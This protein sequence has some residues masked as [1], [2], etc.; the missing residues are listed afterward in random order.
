MKIKK[1]LTTMAILTV[2]LFAGCKKDD[3]VE[4]IGV[5]PLVIST[6]PAN[7]A[8]S[9]PYYKVI[10][11]KFNEKMDAAT[12]TASSFTLQQ[13]T[14]A[15][16]GTVTYSDST[17][18]FTPTVAL[19]V[20][21]TYKGTIKNTAKDL[22]GNALQADYVWT[23]TTMPQ[24]SLQASPVI[25][26]TT[27][28]GGSFAIGASVTVTAT[29]NPG[30][31]FVN[32]TE[33]GTVVSLVNSPLQI[34]ATSL[35]NNGTEVSTSSS[36]TFIM[37]GNRTLTANFA[38]IVLGN[39]A[40]N[41]SSNPAAGG[42]TGGGGTFVENSSKTVTANANTGYTF[43]NWT[44]GGL[45]VSTNASYNFTLIANK[46]LVANFL[47]NT[48]SLTTS[49][50]NGSVAKS[51]SQA[52][53]NF[54]STVVLTPTANAGYSF[55]SWTGDA[56]GSSNPL[57][58]IMN[59]N[60]AITANFTLN[61][62]TL[63]VISNNGSV[64]KVPSQ[65]TYNHGSTVQ[66][67]ATA[68]FGYTFTSWSGDATG[69]TNPLNV[70][71]SS[72]KNITAN[73]TAIVGALTLNVTAVNGTV[74]KDP[75]L[76]GYLT[77][78]SVILTATPNAGYEF[79]SW[80]GDA[81]GSVNP[82]TIIMNANKNVTAN[83]TLSA[84]KGPGTINLGG[85]AI[86]S[87]LSKTGISTTVGT[88]VTG[89]IGVSPA[90]AT[91]ITGFGLIMDAT[92]TFSKSSP[93]TLVSGKVYAADYAA[94]TPANIST[95]ISDMETAFTTANGL[96]TTVITEL[97]AGDIT[98]MTLV[99]GLYKW[100]TGL[101][102]SASGVTLTGGAND[103]WVFQI[104]Q[105]MTV[106][107]GAIIHLAGGAQAKNIYWITASDAIINSTVEFNGNILSQTLIAL[108][109][110]SKVTGRLLGQTAVTLDAATV[111]FP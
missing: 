78:A 84:P 9:V 26:G 72:N 86:Y 102:I 55:T 13:G 4:T 54:G 104:G 43:V 1:L 11:A 10:T 75:N 19:A 12:I 57:S 71:M 23:F 56:S 96:T 107:S 27:I 59:A 92:N 69:S 91:A 109:T 51:P 3:Y 5:C 87:V 101:L 105:G 8:N 94:P 98:G 110:G 65:V 58:V 66:L 100:S 2:V 24:I 95:A 77:G 106:A 70:T 7:G 16:S 103:T 34:N 60:K 14:T 17:A 41:L 90:A 85:A 46:T 64:V 29:P 22:L 63:N 47:I 81:T 67:T 99:P 111:V 40:I 20:F 53:Y 83:F 61:T 38:V 30:Y 37:A 44:E 21:T 97:G 49:A 89:N 108:K 88:S 48:Y 39:F 76:I 45:I 18:T 79:T 35:A 28:G 31:V 42:T 36:Y 32:W 15:I 80:S 73:Y 25:G 52:T 33:N 93:S 68:N 82:T 74:A 6:D 50:V 62:Y